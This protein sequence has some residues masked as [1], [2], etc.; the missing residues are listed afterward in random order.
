VS[1]PA[2]GGGAGPTPPHLPTRRTG[3]TGESATAAAEPMLRRRDN[4]CRPPPVRRARETWHP[5]AYD[6]GACVTSLTGVAHAR[7]RCA[8]AGR[9]R[10]ASAILLWVHA[11]SA[12]APPLPGLTL[13]EVAQRVALGQVNVTDDSSSR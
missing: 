5:V 4:L 9:A 8:V 10:A 3:R 2:G 6:A 1:S 11:A 13:A 7:T 12:D